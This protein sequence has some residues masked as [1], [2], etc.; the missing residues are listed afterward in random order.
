MVCT[1]FLMTSLT[2]KLCTGHIKEWQSVKSAFNDVIEYSIN[3]IFTV[4]TSRR[5]ASHYD[6]NLKS[7]KC[8]IVV[9]FSTSSSSRERRK[10][11]STFVL[12][13]YIS[14]YAIY[15]S[16]TLSF[17]V[18]SSNGLAAFHKA[19]LPVLLV[20]LGWNH[21]KMHFLEKCHRF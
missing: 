19:D 3:G 16:P 17:F 6:C 8:I 13:E 1:H 14:F 7:W 5:S 12:Q 9:L 20:K 21:K 18:F 4:N 10:L 2:S 15:L 11:G